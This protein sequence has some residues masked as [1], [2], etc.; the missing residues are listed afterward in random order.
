MS[1]VALAIITTDGR[2]AT[3]IETVAALQA[4][5]SYP[6]TV[7]VIF[8]DDN[9]DHEQWLTE[10]FPDF[11]IVTTGPKCGYG[12]AF[13]RMYQWLATLGCAVF[14]CEDDMIVNRPVDV[15]AMLSVL[16]AN[17][18][19][20]ELVLKRQAWNPAEIEAGGVIEQ[21]PDWYEDAETYGHAWVRHSA[22]WSNNTCLIAP[23]VLDVG[24][25]DLASNSE[26]AFTFALR[27]ARPYVRFGYWRARNEPPL[28]THIGDIRVGGQY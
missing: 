19:L 10:T 15:A 3:L 28:I 23:W 7:R 22:Y 25:P 16:N 18:D 9:P 2:R 11:L 26:G 8:C 13:V 14:F 4:N 20:A 12:P 17:T 27:A 6:F 21:H 5:V 1:G 24:W